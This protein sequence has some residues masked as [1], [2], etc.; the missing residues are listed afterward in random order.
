MLN[1]AFFICVA[2]DTRSGS[3]C[4]IFFKR[5]IVVHLC[6]VELSL[7]G[8]FLAGQPINCVNK[9]VFPAAAWWVTYRPVIIINPLTIFQKPA[10]IN[11]CRL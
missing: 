5:R 3:L 4:R 1:N 11:A 2:I 9:G 7:E 8:L 10:V 6:G